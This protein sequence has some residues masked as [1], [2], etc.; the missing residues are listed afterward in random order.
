MVGQGETYLEQIQSKAQKA[1]LIHHQMWLCLLQI[2]QI[3]IQHKNNY[4]CVVLLVQVMAAEA[5]G[6]LSET[7]DADVISAL[8][9]ALEDADWAVRKT[10][11]Q[12]LGRLAPHHPETL[13]VSYP[14]TE[15]CRGSDP[16]FMLPIFLVCALR[17]S[18]VLY[19]HRFWFF[20]VTTLC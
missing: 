5:L 13:K 20:F 3:N 17:K 15:R 16:A 10:A 11:T 6:M 8:V 2:K 18:C 19:L 14:W 9:S 12:A 1:G 4:S 7:E